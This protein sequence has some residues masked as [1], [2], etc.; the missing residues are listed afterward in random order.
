[1]KN[2]EAQRAMQLVGIPAVSPGM[3][4][5]REQAVLLEANPYPPLELG[6]WAAVLIC[7]TVVS[8]VQVT[9]HGDA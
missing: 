5:A 4:V 2:P 9:A 6:S 8:H 1:M 3:A 7:T